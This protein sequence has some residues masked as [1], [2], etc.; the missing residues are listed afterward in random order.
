MA[1]IK[2]KHSIKF[3][4]NYSRRH[5]FTNT[6]NPMNGDAIFDPRLTNTAG[7]GN[8]GH[9]LATMLL[10]FPTEIR[11]GQGNTL[12]QGRIN[13][14]ELFV[15][16][17]FR[18]TSRLTINLG[19]RYE[20]ENAPYD[21]TDRLGNLWV[22]RDASTGK[23]IGTL[24]WAGINPEIDP[25][26]GQRNQPPKTAGFGR[27]LMRNNYKN[28]APRVGLAWTVTPKTVVRTAYGIFYN[29][30]FVQELQDMRKFWPYTVQRAAGV[31]AEYRP[32]AGSFHHRRRPLVQQHRSHRRMAAESG[33]PYAVFA[34]MELHNPAA[35]AR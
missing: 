7:I 13:A 11:R 1:I 16:D 29:S 32:A 3:G 30:T 22:H 28:F 8:S 33:E 25:E 9:A 34:A 17:D 23:Y 19:L 24:L 2:G 10:G 21:V 20:Y 14:P 18:V 5:F 6:A 27:S 15:Q 26:T 35:A 12:T 31:H 4:A